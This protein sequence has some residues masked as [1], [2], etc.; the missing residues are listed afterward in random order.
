MKKFF[1]SSLILFSNISVAAI[2][3]SDDVQGNTTFSDTPSQSAQQYSLPAG[4]E[5]HI[6]RDVPEEAKTI[7]TLPKAIDAK[8]V[9]QAVP[10]DYTTFTIAAPTDQENIQNQRQINVS[11]A[12]VPALQS[13]HTVQL[14]LD[15]APLSKPKA[16]LNFVVEGLNRG[17]HSIAAAILDRNGE[18]VKKTASVTFYIHYAQAKH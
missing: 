18:V 14:F 13:T 9:P 17:Q 8:S 3:Q 4:N 5:I 1:L 11:I 10:V 16:G 6:N 12:L 15:G 7:T 2:Y